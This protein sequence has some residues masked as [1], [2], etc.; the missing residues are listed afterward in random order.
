M[1][2][3]PFLC[4][5]HHW[6]HTA[7]L[8]YSNRPFS[9]VEEMNEIMIQ[10]WNEKI[11]KKDKVIYLGDFCLANKTKTLEILNRLNYSEIF[12]TPGNHD[13]SLRGLK[14]RFAVYNDI[15]N[16]EILDQYLVCCHYS[17]RTWNRMHNGAI[18]CHGHSHGGIKH[19]ES[20]GK[21]MDV[22]VDT[23]N[24]YPYHWDEIKE[25]M[26]KISYQPNHH[27]ME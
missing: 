6:W 15:F 21:T 13:K 19:N 4:S 3:K 11:T 10:R 22:G 8:K 9:S 14:D 7:V 24:F 5:D 17:L 20:H 1:I 18:H 26:D 25:R 12:I 16:I 27:D 23:N 2:D